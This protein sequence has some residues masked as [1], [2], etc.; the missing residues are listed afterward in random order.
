MAVKIR[1]LLRLILLKFYYF[2]LTKVYGMNISPSAR[3][4][5]G[6]KIDKTY[7]SGI[8]ISD[9]SYVA[10]GALI[11]SH[12]YTRSIYRNTYIGKRCFIG[13]N[14]IIMPGITIGNSV[15]VGA[16]AVVTVDVPSGCIVAGNPARII[17]KN[18]STDLYGRLK[19]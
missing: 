17:K 6:A 19:I 3:I 8:Y 13:A 5:L 16:G 7:P 12:D 18:I 11:F 10:S 2:I 1:N 15:I 9:E 14:S 4:S